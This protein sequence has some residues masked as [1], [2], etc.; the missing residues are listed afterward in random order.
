M[1][2]SVKM[3]GHGLHVVREG[4]TPQK[5]ATVQRKAKQDVAAW[6]R[7]AID[8]IRRSQEEAMEQLRKKHEQESNPLI[9][10]M[11]QQKKMLD[12]LQK[13]LRVQNLCNKIAASLIRGDRVPPEDLKYLAQHDIDGYRLA[14]AMRKPKRNP[15]ECKSVLKD[16]D[17]E[18]E[19]DTNESESD[20][21][22]TV[23]SGQGA[24][25]SGC[26]TGGT[27]GGAD[28]GGDI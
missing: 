6:S 24:A 12:M 8:F 27:S 13:Q 9:D 17:K 19:S 15:E 21:V 2:I 25:E 20:P 7:Q 4:V 23:S 18:S 28:T 5:K 26:P 1:D 16:E 14:L 3:N 10:D 22:E 11:E